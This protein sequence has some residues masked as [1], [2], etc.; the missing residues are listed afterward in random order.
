MRTPLVRCAV[1]ALLAFLGADALGQ[2]RPAERARVGLVLGGGGARGAAHIGVLEVLEENRVPIDCIA[3]TSMGGIVGGAYAAGV[4]PAELTEAIRRT[5]WTTI[6]DDSGGRG[7]VNQRRKQL[8]DR[9]YSGLEFGVSGKGLR[10]REG[11]FAAE[12]LKLFFNEVVRADLGERDIEELALPLTLIATDIGSGERVA[13]R[14]GSLTSAMR[15]SMSVPGVITPVVRD[16]RKLVDGGLVDN[17][18]ISEVKERCNA[19]VVIAVN[20]GT[21]MMKPEE[22]TGVVSVVGQMVNLLAEQNVLQSLKLLRDVDIYIRPELGNVGPTDFTRQLESARLGREAALQV[23]DRLKAL[24]LP[25]PAYR[26]WRSAARLAL[27]PAAPVIDDIEVAGTRFLNPRSVRGSL[28][29]KT[30]EPLDVR[31]L[32]QDLV[33]AYSQGDLQMLDYSVLR[34]PGKTLLR[35]T[36]IEKSWGPDYLRFGLNLSSD[37][38]GE[39]QYNLRANYRMTWLNP[40]GGEWLSTLQLGSDQQ[41]ATEFYQP[42]DYRHRVFARAYAS[43]G[44]HK[45]GFFADG[46]RLA[47]YRIEDTR[48]GLEAGVNLGVYGQARMGWLER[49]ANARVDTGGALFP[50]DTHEIGAVTGTLALDTQDHGYF[51]SRGVRLNL[52]F[53]DTSRVGPGREQYGKVEMRSTAAY[54]IGKFTGI[55]ALD[56]G[57]AINGTLPFV[58]AFALGGPRRL[59][60]FAP[61]QFLADEYAF[62]RVELQYPLTQPIPLL[63]FEMI[64]G[65]MYE[66][67]RIRKP[68]TE[69]GLASGWLH[70]YGGYLAANTPLG[71]VYLGFADS[72]KGRSR[73]YLMIGT[74]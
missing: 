62:G 30:G 21:P 29:Q 14:T 9:F 44:S 3:G 45:A 50:D 24:S 49:R 34:E 35:I 58:D 2:A 13:I 8:D 15:A 53:L 16:G 39:S 66:S 57:Q 26:V 59:S 68:L 55:A 43:K 73:F 10:F 7:M 67:A 47:E 52:D 72:K 54:R 40:F 22:V 71:P 36:P 61:S 6:F 19:D 56:A 28:R 70:A 27:P 33:L 5:D 38:R 60:A 18:P 11:A 25:G 23:V 31:S 74:P 69:P 64:A 12:K 4:S 51:P 32:N 1:A 20:V 46:Q 37:F 17:V 63:G 48:V 42:L 65:A 41:V